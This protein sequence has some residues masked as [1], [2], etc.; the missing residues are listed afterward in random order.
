MQT[1]YDAIVK[2][3][4]DDAIKIIK[5]MDNYYIRLDGYINAALSKNSATRF[6]ASIELCKMLNV[7]KSECIH[8]IEELDDF[9][10]N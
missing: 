8:S 9:M 4:N 10:L 6:Y 1:E 3:L 5:E 2:T 7:P